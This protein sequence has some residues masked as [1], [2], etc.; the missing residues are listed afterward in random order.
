MTNFYKM[1]LTLLWLYTL[2]DA[3]QSG[4]FSHYL[5]SLAAQ[6]LQ[7][8]EIVVSECCNTQCVAVSLLGLYS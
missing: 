5:R 6:P 2:K 8:K 3:P 4:L 7:D 1:A